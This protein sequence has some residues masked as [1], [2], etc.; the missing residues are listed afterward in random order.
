MLH[1]FG[2]EA[3]IVGCHVSVFISILFIFE[4]QQKMA[5]SVIISFSESCVV[6][7]SFHFTAMKR[8]KVSIFRFSVRI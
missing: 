5:W 8:Q 4:V 2:T 6:I 3:L 1:P 7:L